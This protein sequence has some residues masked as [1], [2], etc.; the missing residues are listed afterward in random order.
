MTYIAGVALLLLMALSVAACGS[1]GD[2]TSTSQSSGAAKS[3]VVSGITVTEDS[4]LH[5]MLPEDIKS[6]GVLRDYVNTPYPPWS[7]NAEGSDKDFYGLEIDMMKAAAAKL[8]VDLDMTNID[9]ESIITGLQAGKADL[10]TS[11]MWDNKDRQKVLSFVDWAYDGAAFVVLK[12]N[13]EG[14]TGLDSLA[15]KAV[16]C[17]GGTSFETFLK[18]QADEF[19]A[20]GKGK[21]E[22]LPFPKDTQGLLAVKTGRAIAELTDGPMAEYMVTTEAGSAYDVVKDPNAPKGGYLAAYIAVGIPKADTQLVE[23]VKAAYTSLLEDGTYQK[24]TEKYKASSVAV[25]TITVNNAAY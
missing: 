14:F 23:A 6:A 22:V 10:T 20:Q 5:E 12:G 8:G 2:S 11:T 7:Y 3:V 1:S 19:A 25:D 9:F 21:I 17:Q 18:K 15:G 13:P 16:S 4:T 24:L